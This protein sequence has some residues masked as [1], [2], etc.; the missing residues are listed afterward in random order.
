MIYLCIP[1]R[2]SPLPFH[3]PFTI[4]THN[5]HHKSCPSHKTQPTSIKLFIVFILGRYMFDMRLNCIILYQAKRINYVLPPPPPLI[6]FLWFR[7]TK[8]EKMY[9]STLSR[10][11]DL[12]SEP[13]Y[14]V[15]VGTMPSTVPWSQ[16]TSP[17]P[18]ISR[19]FGMGPL[20]PTHPGQPN[21]PHRL[22]YPKKN[23]D[24][25]LLKTGVGF[26]LN[27]ICG[28]LHFLLLF[29][30]RKRRFIIVGRIVFVWFGWGAT[31]ERS[32]ETEAGTMRRQGSGHEPFQ[33]T[34]DQC[35]CKQKNMYNMCEQEFMACALHFVEFK[36]CKV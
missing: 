22:T 30:S 31:G 20:S 27:V 9:P 26:N 21:A 15:P 11:P 29:S 18:P 6:A 2:L 33:S 19:A 13:F 10:A 35:K 36:F 3:Q 14:C 25:K 34:V 1:F 4:L 23:D 28:S 24:G 32:A 8:S 5:Q 7:S 16:P 17:T 12:E